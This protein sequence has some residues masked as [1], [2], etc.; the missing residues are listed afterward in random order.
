[1]DHNTL[2][3]ILEETEIQTTLPVSLETCMQDKN[4]QLEPNMEQRTGSKFG[5]E[6]IKAVYHHPD[7]LTSMQSIS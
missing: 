4:Q 5:K 2:W 6:Y 3:K 7:Y 1:M